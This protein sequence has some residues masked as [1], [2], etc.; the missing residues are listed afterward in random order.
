MREED[1]RIGGPLF[2]PELPA[3]V[4]EDGIFRLIFKND[5]VFCSFGNCSVKVSEWV[6]FAIVSTYYL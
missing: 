5:A 1:V 4:V 3:F 6:Y 2:P